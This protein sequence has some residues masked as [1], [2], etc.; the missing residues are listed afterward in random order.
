MFARGVA[1][2]FEVVTIHH[3]CSLNC[4][5]GAFLSSGE[6]I[7]ILLEQQ[8]MVVINPTALS[9]KSFLSSPKMKS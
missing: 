4:Q 8:K 6:E 2:R 1:Q 7:Y 3:Y 5:S 9:F